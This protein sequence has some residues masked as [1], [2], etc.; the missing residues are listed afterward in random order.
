ML[1]VHHQSY[2]PYQARYALLAL[3]ICSSGVA[4]ATDVSQ[5]DAALVQDRDNSVFRNTVDYRLA[6]LVTQEEWS[7]ASSSGGASATIYGVPVSASY[8]EF[9]ENVRNTLTARSESLQA[10]QIRQ[11]AVSGLSANGLSA[12]TAC[13]AG[14][15]RKSGV[16]LTLGK[17]TD[18]TATVIT[19]F[20]PAAGARMRRARL[21]WA[22]MSATSN[23]GFPRR[24]EPNSTEFAIVQRPKSGSAVLSVSGAGDVD[25]VVIFAPPPPSPPSPVYILSVTAVDDQF[26]CTMNDSPQPVVAVGFG[27]TEPGR[28]LTPYMK[29]GKNKLACNIVDV[30]PEGGGRPCWHYQYTVTRSG[31]TSPPIRRE[32]GTCGRDSQ[33]PLPLVPEYLFY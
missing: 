10:E 11:F 25:Q 17:M 6:T 23:G 27:G 30:H 8:G 21:R 9:Q 1:F 2:G 26:S 16:T 20:Y 33:P 29:P 12:Y 22:G 19:T 15:T 3:L 5:C 31:S 18:D 14:L 32:N 13:V 7:K 4:S 24:I 28:D